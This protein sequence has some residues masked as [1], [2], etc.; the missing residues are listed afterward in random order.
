V[1]YSYLV[2]RQLGGDTPFKIVGEE[3][4]KHK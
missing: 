4:F 3:L 1:N 2:L